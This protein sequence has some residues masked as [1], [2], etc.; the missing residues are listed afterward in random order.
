[1]CP[2]G[3]FICFALLRTSASPLDRKPATS[4]Q[5]IP[6]PS[7]SFRKNRSDGDHHSFHLFVMVISAGLLA[8]V[9][10]R[11]PYSGS[12]F[13]AHCVPARIWCRG[14]SKATS[15]LQRCTQM[16][17]GSSRGQQKREH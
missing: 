16:M 14:A 8:L 5:V 13:H 6:R 12:L 2:Y 15:V 4:P 9:L 1:S 3:I 17:H 11:G 7:A 10:V